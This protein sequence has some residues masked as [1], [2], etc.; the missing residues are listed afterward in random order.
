MIWNSSIVNVVLMM[1]FKKQFPVELTRV[2]NTAYFILKTCF[3]T[4]DFGKNILG[5]LF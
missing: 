1:D 4:L 3:D 2:L 5:S